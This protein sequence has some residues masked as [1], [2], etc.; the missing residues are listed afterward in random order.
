MAKFL[1]AYSGGRGVSTDE[2]ERQRQF[3]KWGAWMGGLGDALVDPGAPFAESKLVDGGSSAGLTGYSV[4]EAP[5]LDAAVA[6][7]KDCPI[8]E[9]GGQVEVYETVPM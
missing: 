7:A 9:N 8:F 2:A 3:E 5:S 6:S 1:L 4:L